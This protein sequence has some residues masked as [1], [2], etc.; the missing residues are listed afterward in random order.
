MHNSDYQFHEAISEFNNALDRVEQLAA[1]LE[2]DQ[3]SAVEVW[4]E[5]DRVYDGSLVSEV[6][7]YLER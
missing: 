2:I 6:Y 1:E 5:R 3:W 4:I 7:N